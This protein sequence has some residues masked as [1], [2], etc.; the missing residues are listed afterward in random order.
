MNAILSLLFLL[1]PEAPYLAPYLANTD[2]APVG[3]NPR[4]LDCVTL[5]TKDLEIGRIAAQQWAVE[6]GGAPAQHCLAIADLAAGFPR[7]AAARLV[8]LSERSDAGDNAARARILAEAALAWLDAKNTTDAEVAITSSR[9]MA[10]DLAEL[11]IVAAKVFEA[12]GQ[13]QSAEDA[14]TSAEEKGVAT[15]ESYVIRARSRRALGRDMAAADDVAASL[16]LDPFNLDAL[17]LRGE[18][19]QAGINIEAYYGAPG[20]EEPNE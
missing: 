5:V 15:P 8:E 18:L 20:D 1:T 7:L 10:P 4:Y 3:A 13:W 12:S 11:D 16:N 17:V 19:Q 9:A 2:E 6:G 14:V